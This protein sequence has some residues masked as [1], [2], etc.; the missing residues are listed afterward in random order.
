MIS[1]L[2]ETLVDEIRFSFGRFMHQYGYELKDNVGFAAEAIMANI[3][4][5]LVGTGLIAD[6][7]IF[8]NDGY[9]VIP[10]EVGNMK[11]GKWSGVTTTDRKP[12]RVFRVDFDGTLWMLNP[13]NTKFEG[14]LMK[15][16]T[17][18]LHPSFHSL[19]LFP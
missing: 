11:A 3:L 4:S 19:P 6:E 17:A 7:Y 12:V 15:F 5:G 16:Y 8:P 9:G 18:R 14:Q 1:Q 13:R 2:H 10:V